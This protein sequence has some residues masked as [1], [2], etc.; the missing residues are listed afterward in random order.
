MAYAALRRMR[1]STSKS[2]K[3][4]AATMRASGRRTESVESAQTGTSGP[5]SGDGGDVAQE[6]VE[7]DV[8][9]DRD[10]D[11]PGPPPHVLPARHP[12][13]G[14]EVDEDEEVDREGEERDS[15]LPGARRRRGPPVQPPLSG[16]RTRAERGPGG[17]RRRRRDPGSARRVTGKKPPIVTRIQPTAT[18]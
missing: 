7:A 3:R 10:E 5:A 17:S 2:R 8:D 1:R 9:E 6:D 12:G 13:E 15:R 18:K 4:V 16:G 11:D 14:E